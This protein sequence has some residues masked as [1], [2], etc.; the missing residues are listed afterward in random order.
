MLIDE[1]LREAAIK[2]NGKFS[3][4]KRNATK[5]TDKIEVTCPIHGKFYQ[6]IRV[7][8]RSTHGCS[9]C[10]NANVSKTQRKT[11]EQYIL[12]ANIAH[13]N[14][15]DYSLLE[16]NGDSNKITII[17]PIHG[18][19][20][21]QAGSHIGKSKCGCKK[22]AILKETAKQKLTKEEVTKRL[23]TPKHVSVDVSHYVNNKTKLP[24][25]CAYHGE[26][27]QLPETLFTEGTTSCPQCAKQLR[28]WNRS[29][30]KSSPTTIYILDLG[31]NL[32]KLG[33]TKSC[34]VYRRY[35]KEDHNLI[36]SIVFQVTI[37]NGEIAWD[38][39]KQV[40]KEMGQYRYKGISIFKNTGNTE[41]FTTDPLTI[42][43]KV[44]NEQL[45]SI[46]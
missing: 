28:G 12:E 30:Y 46:Q 45:F 15:Y 9:K 16:Y 36:K 7:H 34:D 40:L 10:G 3:Y 35:A 38:I 33:I 26:F 22:C 20:T 43:Q 18:P 14:K 25:T 41:I 21:Q 32:Y 8:L 27:L 19:F 44:I 39:E 4:N 42:L 1:K 29:L 24:C 13:N 5:V 31:N 23:K 17:C 11:Q 2:F 37:L 6:E